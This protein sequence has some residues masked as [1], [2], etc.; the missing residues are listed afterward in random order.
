MPAKE[1]SVTE[2]VYERL[3]AY[4]CDHEDLSDALERLLGKADGDWR[5]HFGFLAEEEGQELAEI[6]EQ[7]R[8]DR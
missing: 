6:V 8:K 2:E 5:T 4:K 1:I 3:E 7:E